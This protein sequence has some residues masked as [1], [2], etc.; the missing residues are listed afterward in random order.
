MVLKLRPYQEEAVKLA[1]KV[2]KSLI[3]MNTGTGKTLIAMFLSRF[4]LKKEM[5][6]KILIACTVNAIL[7]FMKDYRD[8]ANLDVD[9]IQD[10]NDLKD[11]LLNKNKKIALFKHSFFTELGFVQANIDLL[12]DILTKNYKRLTL[13]IDE[14]HEFNNVDSN[15]HL[16]YNNVRFAFDRVVLLTATPYSSKLDQVYG[17][18]HLIYPTLWKSLKEFKTL[19][20]LEKAVKDWKTGKFKY[21]EPQAYI[22]L[23]LLRKT[24]EPFTF[25]WFPPVKLNY[26]E[27]KAKLK[28]YTEYDN[29]C[30]GLL[31]EKDTAKLEE[32][33]SIKEND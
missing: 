27:H 23:P 10:I 3:C 28:S 15:G 22:N 9:V 20:V 33:E 5:T 16:A 14:A 31:D 26:I 8:K 11:F 13:I 17:L 24:L 7:V 30:R 29:L 18:A 4:L 2:A 19:F 21:N 32:L 25:F 1:V 12:E 6:D